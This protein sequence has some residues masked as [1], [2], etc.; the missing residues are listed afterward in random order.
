MFGCICLLLF[1]D[2]AD[3]TTAHISELKKKL[4]TDLR[5]LWVEQNDHLKKKRE[6]HAAEVNE[7][8]FVVTLI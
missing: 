6:Q 3:S 4:Q 2:A 1:R 5:T 8:N 7:L